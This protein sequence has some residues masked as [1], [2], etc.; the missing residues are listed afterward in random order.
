MKILELTLT[1]FGPFSGQ[2]F[3]LS[4]GNPGLHVVFGPNEAG[5][6]SALRALHAALYGIPG[7]TN[8]A[9]LHPYN[10]LRIGGR[11]RHSSGTEIAFVRRK[12]SK[13]TLLEP[14]G[15][16]LDDR[17]LDR[18][19]GGETSRTFETFW[20][21]ITLVLCKAAV[22]SSKAVA[23]SGRVSLPRARE[24]HIS[25]RFA[26]RLKTRLRRSTCREVTSVP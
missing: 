2:T 11:L 16:R 4:A 22:T 12:G 25:G 23:I 13:N 5:K 15:T 7:Q 9:F 1:A 21:S 8:D 24:S 18:F 17:A 19:L 26:A 6:S 20:E 3:D 14:D 10:A